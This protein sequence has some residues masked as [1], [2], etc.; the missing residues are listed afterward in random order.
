MFDTLP[1]LARASQRMARV[2]APHRADHPAHDAFLAPAAPRSP[3]S[4]GESMAIGL[5]CDN[6]KFQR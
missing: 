6:W 4:F 1:T 2:R 5:G 3:L